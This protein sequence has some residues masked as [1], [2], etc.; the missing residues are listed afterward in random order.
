[1]TR[2]FAHAALSTHDCCGEAS[3][4]IP[5]KTSRRSELVVRAIFLLAASAI[6]V[7]AQASSNHDA[8]LLTDGFKALEGE[9]Q[10]DGHFIS[11]GKPL[12][13]ISFRADART[14]ALIVRHDDRPPGQYHALELWTAGNPRQGFRATLVDAFGGT[15]WFQSPGWDGATLVWTRYDNGK[16]A[17]QFAYEIPKPGRLKI[18][19]SVSRENGP[20]VLGDTLDCARSAPGP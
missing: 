16:P 1:M 5:I 4:C 8:P 17:E 10:C 18:D 19:W 2:T 14:A 6:A 15:R 20:M 11:S 12:S 9:W 3:I 13:Q 7:P